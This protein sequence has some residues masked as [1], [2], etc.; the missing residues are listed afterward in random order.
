MLARSREPHPIIKGMT[1][2]RKTKSNLFFGT[3]FVVAG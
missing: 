2:A 1:I 3:S